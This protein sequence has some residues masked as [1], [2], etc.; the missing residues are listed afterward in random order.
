MSSSK[1]KPFC[2]TF[3]CD[4]VATHELDWPISEE[5][6]GKPGFEG[7]GVYCDDCTD[8]LRSSSNVRPL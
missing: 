2:D 6:R 4:E 3:D 8:R 5:L 7:H 1:T